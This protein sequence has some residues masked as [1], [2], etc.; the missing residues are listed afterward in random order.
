MIET[1]RLILRAWREAD[2]P[3][4]AAINGDPR[5]GDWLGGAIDR[6]ASDA[7]MD[8]LQAQIDADGFGFW[9][10]ERREDGRL[11]GMIGLRRQDAAPPGPCL[12]LGWRLSPD[13]Q[14]AGLATEG[15][16]A[17][18]DWGFSNH[19]APEILPG[20]AH[21]NV[22]SQAA[23][24]PIGRLPDFA[25]GFGHPTPAADHPLRRDAMSAPRRP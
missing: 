12:E 22:R 19:D 7:V 6:A 1:P 8:R 15:A 4:F 10:A 3:A 25:P 18:L 23:P 2:R 17:A 11:V 14:G 21:T 5:V 9:A 16:K 13:A 24:R 20:T